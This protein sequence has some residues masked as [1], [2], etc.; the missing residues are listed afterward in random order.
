MINSQITKI[1][2]IGQ[3]DAETELPTDISLSSLL[4]RVSFLIGMLLGNPY[5]MMVN[6]PDDLEDDSQ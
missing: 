2:R 6:Q 1:N 5:G 4:A 3:V